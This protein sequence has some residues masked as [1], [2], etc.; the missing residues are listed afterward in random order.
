MSDFIHL[1]NHTDYSLLDAAQTV[2]V[3]CSRAYDLG[4]DSIAVTDHGNLFAM[5]PF[6]QEAKKTGIKPILGCEIYVAVNQH[7]DKKQVSTLN[8]KKWGYHHLVLLAQNLTGYQ[9]LMKLCSIGYLEGFYYRPRVDKTLLKEFNEGL[10]ATSGCL[11]GEVTAHAAAGD[12][13]NAKKAALEYLEIF[14]NRFYLELQN[15]DIADEKKNNNIFKK[16]I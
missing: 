12:Y 7:T 5:L 15:H 11:A 6:Y 1:H 16:I 8:G 9:N 4:M 2:D 14:P 10:I 3:M 13:D